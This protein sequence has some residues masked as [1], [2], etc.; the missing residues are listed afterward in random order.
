[1]EQH[2]CSEPGAFWRKH[3]T[4]WLPLEVRACASTQ[5]TWFPGGRSGGSP[6]AVPGA[7]WLSVFVLRLSPVCVP[8]CLGASFSLLN[9]ICLSEPHTACRFSRRSGAPLPPSELLPFFPCFL[10]FLRRRPPAFIRLPEASVTPRC[11]LVRVEAALT[12]AASRDRQRLS[13]E[14]GATEFLC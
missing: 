7:G 6:G 3:R 1:M 12:A 5:T 2:R 8:C 13:L 4:L 14:E 10:P 11:A 9:P